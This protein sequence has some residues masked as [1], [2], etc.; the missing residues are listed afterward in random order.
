MARRKSLRS[1]RQFTTPILSILIMLII[2][3]IN[4]GDAIRYFVA[5]IYAIPQNIWQSI[6]T[7][8]LESARASTN[9]LAEK[10]KAATSIIR[11]KKPKKVSQRPHTIT[12]VLLSVLQIS[13]VLWQIIRS[14]VTR[15][16]FS[17]PHISLPMSPLH[18][19]KIQ[20]T[21]IEDASRAISPPTQPKATSTF[22]VQ[23]FTVGMGITILFILLPYNTF[24]FLRSLPNPQMLM[25][26]DLE[27]T[28]KIF[29][30]NGQLLYEI[31]ADQNRTPIP[32]TKIPSHVK[33]ATIA[34]E[35]HDFYSH[36]G[37]SIRGIVR[38]A[39]EIA[40]NKR[41]QGGSTI[42]QQLI[43]SALLTPDVNIIRKTKELI[44][45]FWA[46]RIYTKDQILEMYF[47]Q[48]PYGGTAW[49]IES[50]AQTY[51]R[52]S[53]TE[54]NLAEAALLA[55]LPAA[56]TEYSPFGNHPDKAFIRQKE[57]LRRMHADGIITVEQMNEA[58]AFP[59]QFAKQRVAIRAP[60]FVMYVKQIL[61]ERFGTRLVERGGLR[62]VTSLDATIQEKAEDIVRTHVASL[63]SLRVGNGA[64][65]IT[66]PKT[67][68]ILAMVGSHDYFD[69]EH[70]GNVNI[71][72]SLRQPGSS[73][74]VVTYAAA[75]EK[76]MT[77]ATLLSD[78]PISYPQVGGPPYAPVNYDGKFH[79]LVPLRSAL[80]NSYNIPAVKLLSQLG[81]PAMLEKA[82]LM[83]VD[84]W[85]SDPSRYGLS[86]TLGG[87]EV[88]MLEMAKIYGTFANLGKRQDLL[89]IL[90]VKDYTGQIIEQ[91][92]PKNPVEAI[93]EDV[94]WIMNN[95]LADNTART[96]A[97]GPNSSLVIPGYTVSVKT[98]TTN[99]KRD[100]W[101][102]GFTPSFTAVV[103]VGNND[104][105]PMDPYL[106]S[107]ITGA[108]PI[109]HD[110]MTELLKGRVDES[111]NTPS[112]VISIPCY[113]GK[114]EYFVKGTEPANGRCTAIPTPSPTPTP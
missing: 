24:L 91:Y 15:V 33:E 25:Q 89:P 62:I 13:Y 65:V 110:I 51:F 104:N 23:S 92:S 101:T 109:W 4:I 10:H 102:A 80:A 98:G 48:V 29:D 20:T 19:T 27:V 77:A 100:N 11:P 67:G 2:G 45:A 12:L 96:P 16:H 3:L 14:A 43:K 28:S 18:K 31:Y 94:A 87:G 76:G 26:R 114:S 58:L 66:N 40:I 82:R 52:K 73:I 113:F 79:G 6:K 55:G 90:E 78:T 47:N 17:F 71:V 70:D 85:Q 69:T 41:V 53:V 34:I 93:R 72:T 21:K 108:A 61:E 54:I 32:L 8:A 88:T 97:F 36:L 107:G 81:V 44:L 95:I 56:P 60:H 103:W 35:D 68:E 84:S 37:F 86:L 57:V 75:M 38:S 50:A 105:T 74:K 99:E 83:G 111:W 49:G 46:E 22:H 42:T 112:T 63:A 1:P 64:A 7:V 9:W 5:Y 59:V 30:R 106:T 39:K